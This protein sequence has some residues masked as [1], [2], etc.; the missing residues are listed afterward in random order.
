MRRECFLAA[1]ALGMIPAIAVAGTA[2]WRRYVI[3]STGASVDIPVSIFTEDA[4]ILGDGAG[5]R[6]VTNDHRADLTVTSV[7][8]VAN[9]SPAAFLSKMHPPAN[10]QYRRVTSRFFAV[11]SIRDGR[12][13]YNRCNRTREYMNCVLINYPAAEERQWDGVVTRISLS[14]AN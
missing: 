7:P 3:P 9:D 13:W 1:L 5:R 11:S 4:G 12:T 2:E 6:F 10:I 14:L 8:N